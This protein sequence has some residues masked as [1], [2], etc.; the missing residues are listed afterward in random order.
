[1]H[2]ML[3]IVCSQSC[4]C[5]LDSIAQSLLPARLGTSHALKQAELSVLPGAG[6]AYADYSY[7]VRF[8]GEHIVEPSPPTRGEV[9]KSTPLRGR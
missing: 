5:G 7:L 8:S 1:M 3:G 6:A 2:S 9:V 4:D